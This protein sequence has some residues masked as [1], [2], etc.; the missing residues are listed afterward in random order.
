MFS[1]FKRWDLL[2]DV[3]SNVKIHRWSDG[4]FKPGFLSIKKYF[5]NTYLSHNICFFLSGRTWKSFVRRWILCIFNGIHYNWIS[6]ESDRF[7]KQ[8]F[9]NFEVCGWITDWK[10]LPFVTNWW[11][12]WCQKL[13]NC[14]TSRCLPLK[15]F[16]LL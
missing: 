11:T 9:I 3:A 2:K 5:E 8:K 13:W 14:L 7:Y 1:G 6:G 10:E 16:L 4:Q 15:L 12:S